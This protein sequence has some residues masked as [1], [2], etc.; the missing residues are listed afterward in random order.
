M[1]ANTKPQQWKQDESDRLREEGDKIKVIDLIFERG[2][3]V[4][5]GKARR[6]QDF[7]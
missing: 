2:H 5:S 7:P 6:E 4:W 3:I 1:V